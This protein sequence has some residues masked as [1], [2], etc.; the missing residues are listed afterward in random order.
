[1]LQKEKVDTTTTTNV[2]P[3]RVSK[4]LKGKASSKARMR[5]TDL[6]EIEK[7]LDS[8]R[9]EERLMG[10]SIASASKADR[11]FTLDTAGSVGEEKIKMKERG[12]IMLKKPLRVDQILLEGPLSSKHAPLY[13]ARRTQN[14]KT[15]IKMAN[16]TKPIITEKESA[17]PM[18]KILTDAWDIS[19]SATS[20]TIRTAK[21]NV[22]P[23]VL[24]SKVPS[25]RVPLSSG[26]SYQPKENEY[27]ERLN[28]AADIEIRKENY[29][30]SLVQ[31][32]CTSVSTGAD[33]VKEDVAVA[34]D[35]I[36]DNVTVS[37][38]DAVVETTLTI[39]NTNKNKKKTRAERNKM[40]LKKIKSSEAK[41]MLEEQERRKQEHEVKSITKKFRK[42]HE[43]QHKILLEKMEKRRLK[44]NSESAVLQRLAKRPFERDLI[45]IQMPEDRT[46]TL[47]ELKP[48]GNLLIERFKSMQERTLIESA[49]PAEELSRERRRMKKDLS[50]GRRNVEIRSFREFK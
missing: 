3:A 28:E 1:M 6:S 25:V 33:D 12:L 22:A 41:K 13:G 8:L 10:E 29:R 42:Q 2:V 35:G 38:K 45:A 16:S 14:T 47:R 26:E 50:F 31:P 21:R 27:Y 39:Q 44:R 30:Q 7:D 5:M 17:K 37:D 4:R 48:E 46:K 34:V 32:I 24:Q 15:R 23:A 18:K 43:E 36:S 20:A 49:T 40:E 11:L 9:R 19:D